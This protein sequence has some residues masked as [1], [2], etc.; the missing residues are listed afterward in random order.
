MTR[1]RAQNYGASKLKR[2]GFVQG[3]VGK[4]CNLNNAFFGAEP[5]TRI[6]EVID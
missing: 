4:E 2:M 3:V 1:A 6:E 5:D